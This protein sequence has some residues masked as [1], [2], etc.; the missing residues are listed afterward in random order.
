MPMPDTIE[1]T[2]AL[3]DNIKHAYIYGYRI[4]PGEAEYPSTPDDLH[5]LF[6][7]CDLAAIEDW[8][9]FE[10][11]SVDK[12][13][14]IHEGWVTVSQYVKKLLKTDPDARPETAKVLR[15]FLWL[16]VD[17]TW[18]DM[19]R[20]GE[21]FDKRDLFKYLELLVKLTPTMETAFES[22]SG[23]DKYVSIIRE[24]ITVKEVS[25]GGR[26]TRSA[27]RGQ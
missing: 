3:K 25:D 22:V 8:M 10:H 11:W 24:H 19:Q 2:L 1:E 17:V 5:S 23:P 20:N 27:I 12:Q 13:R 7:Q 15:E 6:P 26:G 9:S 4:G 14:S 18:E 21:S 16:C